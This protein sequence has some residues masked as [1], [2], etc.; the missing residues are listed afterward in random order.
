[1]HSC[2]ACVRACV[3][4]CV[5]AC[6]LELSGAHVCVCVRSLSGVYSHTLTHISQFLLSHTSVNFLLSFIIMLFVHRYLAL[7]FPY[8]VFNPS[9][10]QVIYHRHC[11][12]LRVRTWLSKEGINTEKHSHTRIHGRHMHS[13]YRCICVCVCV[14]TCVCVCVCV[15]IYIYMYIYMYI[16]IIFSYTHA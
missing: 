1:M 16:C 13:I 15:Y 6:A 2:C 10:T 3:D 9:Y 14:C 5:R 8:I 4:M 11:W 12:Q 7:F